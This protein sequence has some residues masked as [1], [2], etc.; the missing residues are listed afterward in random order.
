MYSCLHVLFEKLMMQSKQLSIPNYNTSKILKVK[1]KSQSLELKLFDS[2]FVLFLSEF[3][4]IIFTIKILTLIYQV[5]LSVVHVLSQLISKIVCYRN[6]YTH[7]TN[8]CAKLRITLGYEYIFYLYILFIEY[9]TKSLFK[10]CLILISFLNKH[11]N[12]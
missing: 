4:N 8:N 6:Y 12:S 1:D 3:I 7:Y 5:F 9:Y 10:D 11:S 2:A